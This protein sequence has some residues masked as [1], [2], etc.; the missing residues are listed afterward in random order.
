MLVTS[1]YVDEFRRICDGE[2]RVGWKNFKFNDIKFE[3]IFAD[4]KSNS[5]GLQLADL[6]ARPIGL[7]YM[8]PE[9]KNR[10]YDIFESK[11]VR[12]KVFP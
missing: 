12:K 5:T 11:I 10:A 9:Q 1:Y 4:K 2:P 7:N 6:T 3:P 8:R